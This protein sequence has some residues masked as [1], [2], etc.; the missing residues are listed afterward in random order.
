MCEIFVWNGVKLHPASAN[1]RLLEKNAIIFM[2]LRTYSVARCIYE[3][4]FSYRYHFTHFFAAESTFFLFL[5]RVSYLILFPHFWSTLI[6]RKWQQLY[7]GCVSLSLWFIPFHAP[8]F[9]L[10]VIGTSSLSFLSIDRFCLGYLLPWWHLIT[11]NAIKRTR[12]SR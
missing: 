7:H 10:S 11:P 12:M 5:K 4:C 1:R 3:N 8:P 6:P 2:L 9:W